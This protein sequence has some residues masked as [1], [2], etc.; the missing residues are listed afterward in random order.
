MDDMKW[1]GFNEKRQKAY[2]G[3]CTFIFFPDL[4]PVLL[5]VQIESLYFYFYSHWVPLLT[6]FGHAVNRGT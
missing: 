6:E 4:V 5:F 2:L 1:M 3:P